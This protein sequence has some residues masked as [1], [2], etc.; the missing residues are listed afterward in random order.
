MPRSD[1]RDPL[2]QFALRLRRRRLTLL[3]LEEASLAAAIWMAAAAALIIFGGPVLSWAWLA[4]GVAGVGTSTLWRVRRRLPEPYQLLQR[5][6]AACRWHDALST[7]WYFSRMPENGRS[8]A[9]IIELQRRTA[10]ELARTADPGRVIPC[11]LPRTVYA[12][13]LAALAAGSLF[14]WRYGTERR[15]DLQPPVVQAAVGIFRPTEEMIHAW[16][17]PDRENAERPDPGAGEEARYRPRR[18]RNSDRTNP[19]DLA[20][21]ADG[22][23]SEEARLPDAA[24]GQPL[25]NADTAETSSPSPLDRA[26]ADGAAEP[27]ARD[28]DFSLPEP[29]NDLLRKMQDAFAKLLNKLDL[30]A[31]KVTGRRVLAQRRSA[32]EQSRREGPQKRGA[33]SEGSLDGEGSPAKRPGG[34]ANRQGAQMMAPAQAEG[35][36]EPGGQPGRAGPQNAAGR[37]NGAKDVRAAE[38]A[39]AM[40]KLAEILGRR[41]R[42]LKGDVMVEVSS[43]PQRLQ[44]PYRETQAVHRGAAAEV[45]RDEIPLELQPFVE[46]YFQEIHREAAEAAG[47]SGTE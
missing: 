6:D 13:A 47:A 32:A 35:Q 38:Q 36:P 39:E 26:G 4:V 40:G 12:A 37:R 42:N 11:R 45:H 15:L 22:E 41:A 25:D 1:H 17:E 5:A 34:E 14:A 44:T 30:K 33:P 7:A 9:E 8:R 29:E 16:E 18:G 24:T 10:E 27:P 21:A 3:V 31:P 43:G 46:R 2:Y 23:A 28:E 19:G 20:G